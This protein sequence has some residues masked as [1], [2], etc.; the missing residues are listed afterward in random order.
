MAAVV[1]ASRF[2]ERHESELAL[3]PAQRVFELTGLNARLPFRVDEGARAG[4]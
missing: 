2:C 4:A 3:V 1:Y